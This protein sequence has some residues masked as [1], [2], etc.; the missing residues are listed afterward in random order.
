MHFSFRRFLGVSGDFWGTGLQH[1][2][3]DGAVG[4]FHVE[5]DFPA[6]HS[7]EDGHPLSNVVKLADLK[8]AVSGCSGQT[9]VA[10]LP[11]EQWLDSAEIS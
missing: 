8:E 1:V 6:G 9:A 7:E 10:V 11:C 3:Q 5:Q 2:W 4:A